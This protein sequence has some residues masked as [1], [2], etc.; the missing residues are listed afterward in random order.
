MLWVLDL[1]GVLW[2]GGEAIPGSADAVGRLRDAGA[3]VAFVTNNSARTVPQYVEA[4]GRAGVEA[5]AAEIVTSSQAAAS[6][7]VAGSRAAYIGDEGVLEALQDRGVEVVAA[8]D[9]PDAVVVGRTLS[10]DFDAMSGAAA[11]VRTGARFVATNTDATFP[12]PRGPEPGAGALVAFLEV[13]SGRRA[14]PAGKPEQPMVDLVRERFG[15]P[16]VVVGDRP[17]TD[18]LFATRLEAPFALVLTGVTRAEDLPVTPEPDLVGADLAA[19]V[20]KR[21]DSG[22]P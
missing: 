18:G 9:R 13:A 10:L 5:D 11:A 1:D 2:L 21:L 16:G 3:A 12:T 17:E 15:S 7:L 6:L 19:V 14:E 4:L 8:G 20:A 22:G